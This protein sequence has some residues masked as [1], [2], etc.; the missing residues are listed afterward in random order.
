MAKKELWSPRSDF[1]S[2]KEIGGRVFACGGG[3]YLMTNPKRGP[4]DLV[5]SV[6]WA[7]SD[8]WAL[9]AWNN[10]P[11]PEKLTAPL[12]PT[13]GPP[14]PLAS[15][16][17]PDSLSFKAVV[18]FEKAGAGSSSVALV[19]A[20]YRLTDGAFLCLFVNGGDGIAYIY[21]SNNPGR[22]HRPVAIELELKSRN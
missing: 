9:R 21:S 15:F 17:R 18:E 14:P 7:E 13:W 2:S 20:K 11:F 19:T 1:P 16:G 6:G 10:P 3:L 22:D 12:S 4:G 8:H 5:R